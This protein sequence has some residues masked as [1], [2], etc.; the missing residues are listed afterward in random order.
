MKH[1]I[2]IAVALILIGAAITFT[3]LCMA[4]WDFRNFDNTTYETVTH[5]PAGDLQNISISSS[6]ADVILRPAEDGTLRVVC[7]ENVKVPHTVTLVDGTLTV[8]SVDN[9]AWYDHIQ[10]F[11][12]DTPKITVYLPDDAYGDLA[13]QG[14]TGDVDIPSAFSFASITVQRSTGDVICRASSETGITI[15]VST[16]DILLMN[17]TAS[18]ITLRTTT[19]DVG[20]SRVSCSGRVALDVD[21][22][23]VTATDLRC[24]SFSSEGTTGDAKLTR[25]IA[26]Q[27]MHLSRSTGDVALDAC[28]AA[29]IDISVSTGDVHG[30][31]L[32]P[33]IFSASAD[34]GSVRVPQS[35]EGGS[36]TI[37]TTTG[38]IHISIS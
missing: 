9:R 6:D 7:H 36:C 2:I 3:A 15:S 20:L 21:T 27:A 29:E 22:G 28:D 37:H 8:K 31:L 18:E 32:S 33:K 13:L 25:V 1:W 4:N 34:T 16:G 14:S 12:F 10:A 19:G 5:E 30:T 35:G 17:A 11:S 26:S 38:D 23:D 24:G